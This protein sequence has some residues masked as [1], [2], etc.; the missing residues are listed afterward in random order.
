MSADQ[1]NLSRDSARAP[2]RPV[3]YRNPQ[4]LNADRHKGRSLRTMTNYAFAARVNSVPMNGNEFPH[5]MHDYPIVFTPEDPITPVVVMGMRSDQNLF[6]T[7]EGQW[8]EGR[9]I[10]AYIRRYPFIFMELT[11]QDKLAL[12]VDE[13][14]SL[15]V[16]DDSRPLF[17]DGKPSE[18]VD[19]ALKYCSEFQAHH[20]ATVEFA[21]ALASHQI[22]IANRA[23]FTI[24]S[25]ERLSIGPFRVIDETKFNQ[26]ADETF[27]EWRRRGWLALVYCHLASLSNFA[28]LAALVD[29]AAKGP[30]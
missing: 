16:N 29:K 12:C 27:L 1:P 13:E 17:S 4:P 22:L 15:L 11:G 3:L 7:P 21:K 26:L 20:A 19:H 30:S 25:G 5:I 10:P 18:V 24:S 6:V 2:A 28:R 9:Y 23:E 8:A 14:S